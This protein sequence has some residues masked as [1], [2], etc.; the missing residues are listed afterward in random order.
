MARIQDTMSQMLHTSTE[1]A[2]TSQEMD[3]A[4]RDI[5]TLWIQLATE[6]ELTNQ[7]W[8]KKELAMNISCI[9]R[10]KRDSGISIYRPRCRVQDIFRILDHN[11]IYRI[12]A[13]YNRNK[14]NIIIINNSNSHAGHLQESNDH[15]DHHLKRL[16]LIIRE[17]RLTRLQIIII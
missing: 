5:N 11:M 12:S 14:C 8:F 10:K 16:G 3:M 4:S 1:E 7:I 17:I 6:L 2:R 9:N 13:I 15:R